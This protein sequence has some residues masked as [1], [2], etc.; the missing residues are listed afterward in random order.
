[1]YECSGLRFCLCFRRISGICIIRIVIWIQGSTDGTSLASLMQLTIWI[2]NIPPIQL[3]HKQSK[4]PLNQ[5]TSQKHI[6]SVYPPD[7]EETTGQVSTDKV[8]SLINL[9]IL[10]NLKPMRHIELQ[11]LI[12]QCIGILKSLQ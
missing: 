2:V 1:M 4:F 8:S 10:L 9:L 6:S 7:G 12:L 3:K 11:L 5:Y